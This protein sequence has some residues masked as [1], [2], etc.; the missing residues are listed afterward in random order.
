LRELSYDIE[1]SIDTFMVRGEGKK[2]IDRSVG[3]FRKAKVRHGIASEIRDIKIRVEEVAKRHDRYKL[4]NSNLTDKHV[5][6]DPRLFSQ[7]KKVT[8]LVGI[9]D[10][11]D[12]IIRIL[13]ECNA[14]PKQQD[15]MVS[16]VGFGGLGKTTLAN[17]VYEKL[18]AQ[19]ECSAFV[20]VSQTPDLEKL[21]KHMFYKLVGRESNKSSDVISELR[22]FL[23]N[24]R[25]GSIS[26]HLIG[27]FLFIY[28]FKYGHWF[29]YY[30]NI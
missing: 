17:V 25:Y 9:E 21:L 8:E 27:I 7:Y 5:T 14:V 16:I 10:V 11:R 3:L 1:D 28:I 6:V 20:S 29:Y 24:K 26:E 15:K 12:E 2:F 4:V 30:K 19:F 23:E 13:M 22:E 18:R